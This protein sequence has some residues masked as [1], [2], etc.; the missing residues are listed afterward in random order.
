MLV[1][2]GVKALHAVTSSATSA[3]A[4]DVVTSFRNTEFCLSNRTHLRQRW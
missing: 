2:V 3:T 1:S 4:A